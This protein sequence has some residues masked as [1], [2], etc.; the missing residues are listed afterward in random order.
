MTGQQLLKIENMRKSFFGTEVL[1]GVNLELN[2]GE[3]LGLIGENGAGKSTLMSIIGGIYSFEQGAMTFQGAPYRPQTPNDATKA[4]IAFI[5]QEF[6]LFSNLT[7]A[8][9]LFVDDFPL[10]HR[11][12]ID[13]KKMEQRA[14]AYI[15]LF[16]LNISPGTKVGSLPMGIRQIVEISKAL[17]KN[18]NVLIF[19]EPTTSLSPK[20]KEGLFTVINELKDSGVAIIYISHILEDVMRLCD[21]TTVLRDGNTVGSFQTRELE[22]KKIIQLMVGRELNQV[23]PSIE[24]EIGP[25]VYEATDFIKRKGTAPISFAICKGEIVGLFG[26][27]GAGR[28][29]LL[30]SLFGVDPYAGGRVEIE[31]SPLERPTPERCI[32]RGMA[33]VT[34]NRRNEGLIL[35]KTV[36]ENAVMVILRRMA[37]ALGV[38]D[39]KQEKKTALELVHTFSVKTNASQDQ[40][41]K[42]LSG[43]N[44]QKVVVA[45]WIAS[46][47][48]VFFMDEPTRGVDVG[49]KYEI[50]TYINELAKNGCG[51]LAVSSEMEELM[52]ICDRILVMYKDRLV[53]NIPKETFDQE[54][55][56]QY[57]LE[58]GIADAG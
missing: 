4:G 46:A 24:K 5:H 8:E 45:K 13:R 57:A 28:T 39:R 42:N 55:I 58:G 27:M 7:V 41:V 40:P 51:V 32:D 6:S 38:V 49:A 36:G 48:K 34:E 22:K 11:I 50:Y 15:D 35:S 52:G 56:I 37:G 10:K 26:L 43:G 16:K 47:P 2:K 21:R 12:A 30:N 53:A 54:L 3:V 20:E 1:H 9:N 44:Q 25:P 23:Y 33:Y 29:E 17:L 14:R 31:Q 18:A 19:D